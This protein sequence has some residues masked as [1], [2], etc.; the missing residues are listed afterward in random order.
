MAR[1]VYKDA[2]IAVEQK[3]K[4]NTDDN[5][6]IDEHWDE[7]EKRV[8]DVET[9][10]ADMGKG[11]NVIF[12][13]ECL[14]FV[15]GIVHVASTL[16]NFRTAKDWVKAVLPEPDAVSVLAALTF[17]YLVEKGKEEGKKL[18]EGDPEKLEK[19]DPEKLKKW[20]SIRQRVDSLLQPPKP[21]TAA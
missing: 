11:G 15:A 7:I 8:L 6:F 13:A 14:P 10:V 2:K 19:A 17:L 12:V 21:P 5:H 3:L 16:D 18:A 1:D 20:E 4:I 9:R